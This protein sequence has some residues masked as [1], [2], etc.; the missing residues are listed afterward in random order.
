MCKYTVPP[1][2]KDQES[3]REKAQLEL[4]PKVEVLG[5]GGEGEGR[6]RQAV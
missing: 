5:E 3:V 1:K 2:N 6:G 4:G